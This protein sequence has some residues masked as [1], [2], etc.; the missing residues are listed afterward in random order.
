MRFVSLR[1]EQGTASLAPLGGYPLKSK[2]VTMKSRLLTI[3]L[4]YEHRPKA[5]F[6][7][8]FSGMAVIGNGL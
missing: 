2:G 8:V 5:R 1:S 4:S 7:A 3:L 6:F